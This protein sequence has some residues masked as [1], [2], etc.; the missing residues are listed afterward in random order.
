MASSFFLSCFKQTHTSKRLDAT[1]KAIEVVD[2]CVGMLYT[3][4]LESDFTLVVTADHGNSDYMLDEEDNV[5]TSHSNSLVPL[6]ITDTNYTLKNGKLADIAPTILDIMGA[7][8]PEEMKG[9]SL[10]R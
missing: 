8:I 1:V 3:K 9:D 10:I 6:I 5:I 7:P 4:C 2:E